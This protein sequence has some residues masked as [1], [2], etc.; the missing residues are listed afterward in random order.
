M[1][2][3]EIAVATF[4]TETE[5]MMWAE[6]LRNEGILSVLVPLGAG[7]AALGSTVWRPFELRVRES[8]AHRA[9]CILSQ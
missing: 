1:A 5:A 9:K 8:D 6:L 7:A 3:R 2:E 4:N